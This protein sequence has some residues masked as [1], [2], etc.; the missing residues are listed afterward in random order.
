[1]EVFFYRCPLSFGCDFCVYWSLSKITINGNNLKQ[2][3]YIYI[4][5]KCMYGYDIYIYLYV[6]IYISLSLSSFDISQPCFIKSQGVVKRKNQVQEMHNSLSEH[7][8]WTHWRG[9]LSHALLIS[10]TIPL[11]RR[12]GTEELKA[13]EAII[14]NWPGVFLKCLGNVHSLPPWF[15]W[16]AYC[17]VDIGKAN[18]HWQLIRKKAASEEQGALSRVKLR[19]FRGT[20]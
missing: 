20:L 16:P 12:V 2:N 10:T 18:N 1:M 17:F 7:T 5:C 14:C 9:N 4:L 19:L 6:Y 13:S 15:L 8:E 11:A 3:L